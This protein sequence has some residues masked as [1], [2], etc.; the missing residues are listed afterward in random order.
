MTLNTKDKKKNL[1]NL[2]GCHSDS[3]LVSQI[4]NILNQKLHEGIEPK[5]SMQAIMATIWAMLEEGKLL[6]D[7]NMEE[8][9]SKWQIIEVVEGTYM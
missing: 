8:V 3:Y 7:K 9:T 4:F 2:F 5:T 6:D 1:D